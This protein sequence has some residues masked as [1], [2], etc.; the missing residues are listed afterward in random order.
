MYFQ[1][2]SNIPLRS[3]GGCCDAG[4]LSITMNENQPFD[5]DVLAHRFS[6][7]ELKSF[8]LKSV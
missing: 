6:V 3:T 1:T 4:A 8:S 5:S 2:S 7:M